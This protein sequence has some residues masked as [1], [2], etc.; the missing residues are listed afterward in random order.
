MAENAFRAFQR[1]KMIPQDTQRT[2]IRCRCLPK[3]PIKC[4][5]TCLKRQLKKK[6]K[7]SFQARS[8]RNAGQKYCRMLIL[9]YFRP[10]L[11]YHLSFSSFVLS[12]FEWPLK[13]GFTVTKNLPLLRQVVRICV[14]AYTQVRP[15][16]QHECYDCLSVFEQLSKNINIFNFCLLVTGEE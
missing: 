12:I 4:S 13:P 10:L 9:Q 15:W 3:N 2:T 1:A 5:K 8:S 11:N 14:F 6:T 16:E 7:F